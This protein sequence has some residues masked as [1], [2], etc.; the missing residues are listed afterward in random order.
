MQYDVTIKRLLEIGKKEIFKFF[1]DIDIESAEIIEEIPKE[2]VSIRS[3]DFPIKIKDKSEY[4]FILLLEIQSYW[5]KEK[6]LDLLDYKARFQRKYKLPVRSVMILLNPSGSAV[7]YYKDSEVS[8]HFTLIK[9]W[10]LDA[11]D[12]LSTENFSLF[13]FIP[14]MKNGIKYV[15]NAEKK[16]Y[17]SHK[18]RELKSDLLT[19]L[20]LLTGMRDKDIAGELLRRRRDIMIESPVYDM[21]IEEGIHKGLQEGIQKGRQEGIKEGIRKKAIE[22]ARK[23]LLESIEPDLIARITDLS[24]E[25]IQEIKTKL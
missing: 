3:T 9:L 1:L 23:M 16:I 8:F 18:D 17:Y 2:T 19:S 14:L 10:E 22:D 21:I 12:I 20:T 25:E 11:E 5:K 13:P 7:S 4:E 24:V 15:D 6:L